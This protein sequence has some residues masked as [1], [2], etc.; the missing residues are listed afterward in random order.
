[1][2]D[3]R[4]IFVILIINYYTIAE[5]FFSITIYP[6]Q[7]VQADTT[8]QISWTLSGTQ[9]TQPVPFVLGI[10]DLKTSNDTILDNNV[11]IIKGGEPWKVSVAGGNYKLFL[12]NLIDSSNVYYSAP[13]IVTG[14]I[15]KGIST[16]TDLLHANR[17]VIPVIVIAATIV[18][19]LI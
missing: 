15:S 1:M 18:I 16:T 17:V 4:L 11:D 3:Y 6:L 9:P 7:N 10:T 2:V 19:I 12:R 14:R 5:A 8:V 13:F